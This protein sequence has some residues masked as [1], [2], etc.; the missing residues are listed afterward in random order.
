MTLGNQVF[1]IRSSVLL[2]ST[3]ILFCR[4]LQSTGPEDLNQQRPQS[5]QK[6]TWA[7]LQMK[8]HSFVLILAMPCCIHGVLSLPAP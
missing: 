8:Y 7:N 6:E 2:H 1:M 5:D 3:A 4:L